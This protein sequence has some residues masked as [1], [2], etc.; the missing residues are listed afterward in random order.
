MKKGAL[1]GAI[2]LAGGSLPVIFRPSGR[3]ARS[4]RPLAQLTAAEYGIFAAIAARLVLGDGADA[5]WPTTQTMDCAGKLDA[6]LATLHGS[7]AAELRALLRTFENGMTGLWATGR[8]R[9]FT[10]SS[11]EEQDRRLE[12]WRRSRIAVFRSGY[13]AL[14]RLAHATYYASPETF[15]VIGYPG[16]PVVPVPG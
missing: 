8:P 4:A 9:T 12:A 14:K 11:A 6:V 7:A 10:A 15:A 5:R 2:L 13:Q 16:P 1:G 3:L